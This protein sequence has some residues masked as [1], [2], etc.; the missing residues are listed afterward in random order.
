MN[1]SNFEGGQNIIS[2]AIDLFLI[3]LDL[4]KVE[5]YVSL[6]RQLSMHSNRPNWA[7][8]ITFYDAKSA[9]RSNEIIDGKLMQMCLKF[10]RHL[11]RAI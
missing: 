6:Y 8:K 10:I 7:V 1:R 9:E 3:Q 2:G 11:T 4:F 5:N